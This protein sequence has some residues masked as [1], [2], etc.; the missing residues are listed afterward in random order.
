MFLGD[1]R[2]PSEYHSLRLNY[3]ILIDDERT[4]IQKMMSRLGFYTI[5]PQGRIKQ[6][7][8]VYDTER[9]LLTGAGLILRKKI[10]VNRTYFSLVRV[11]SIK[12]IELREKTSFLGECEVK[13]QPNDFPEQIADEINKIFN[14][15]FTINL[16]DVVKHCTPYIGIDIVANKYKIVSGTGYELEIYFETLSIKDFRTGRR[17]K[18]RNF[19]IKMFLDPNYEKERKRILE[20]IDRFCKELVLLKRNHFEIAEV[21]VRIP[22]PKPENKKVEGDKKK[23]KKNQE[24]T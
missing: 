2:K 20:V 19:S 1:K 23:K 22:E 15:L 9:K 7:E 10:D 5:I 24:E 11:S 3:D 6:T 8:I 18:R 21:A 14:N 4:T 16:V 13:D 17:A 12:D